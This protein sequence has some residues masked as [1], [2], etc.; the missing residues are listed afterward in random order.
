L[1]EALSRPLSRIFSGLTRPGKLTEQNMEAGLEEIRAALLEADVHFTVAKELIDRVRSK[2][3]GAEILKSVDAGQMIVKLFHDE[4]VA[5]M[6]APGEPLRFAKGRPTVVLLAGLQGSGKTTTAAKLALHLRDKQQRKP[7]LVA[8]DLQRPAAVEQ[9]VTLGGQIGVPVFHAPGKSPPKLAAAALDEARRLGCDTVIVDTAGRL[10]IDDELMDEL[11]AV[12]KAAPPDDTFLVCDAMTGQDAVRSASAFVARLP[13]DGVILTK[14]DGDTRG[15]AAL[16]VR[17][18]TGAPVRFAGMGEKLADLAP[19]HADR[20]A[21]RILGMGDVVGLVEKAQGT[22]DEAAAREQMEALLEDRF[23]LEDF[24]KQLQ[25]VKKLGSLRDVVSHLP[26]MPEGFDPDS[27][28]EKKLDH[29]Q[30]VVLSMTPDERRRPELIDMSRKRRIA[31]GSGTSVN[32]VNELLRQFEGMRRMMAQMKKGGLLQ[33][34][35]GKLGMGLGAGMP[36]MGSLM[37]GAAGRAAPAAER[38]DRDERDALRRARKA[39]RQRKKAAR[40]RH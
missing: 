34:L 25:S 29:T 18:V 39:E 8:A 26:G 4:L 23:S 17:Q 27:L 13:L 38:V 6:A 7:L 28:D 14:L 3:L 30:A 19:F 35:A 36:D 32:A 40:R 9:L 33:R 16:S 31:R 20:M 11:V 24:L 15:G 22:I 12:R 5:L 37:P 10:H 1:F 2:A 21:G